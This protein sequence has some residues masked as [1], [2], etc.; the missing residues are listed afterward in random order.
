T[1]SN[2]EEF[3]DW[4]VEGRGHTKVIVHEERPVPL[5]QHMLVG[6][7]M[8]DLFEGDSTEPKIDPQLRR[9]IRDRM[10]A[11][12]FDRDVGGRGRGRG[13]Y[14]RG[15]RWRPPHRADVIARLDREGLLP[16]IT[17]IFSRAG[18]DA[19]VAQCVAANVRLTTDEERD[20]I[21]A[22]AQE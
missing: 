9:Y 2:A 8:F 19:A 16:A 3:G 15:P 18:C 11:E 5:W 10:R 1:V 13:G 7:R 4:L 14:G 20:E 6:N 12:G 22:I 21:R 17:F